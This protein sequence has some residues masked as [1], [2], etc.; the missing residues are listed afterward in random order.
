MRGSLKEKLGLGTIRIPVGIRFETQKGF[1]AILAAQVSPSL[2]ISEYV[3]NVI[4]D[5][6]WINHIVPYRRFILNPGFHSEIGCRFL[7]VERPFYLGPNFDIIFKSDHF[8][9]WSAGIKATLFFGK[10]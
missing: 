1:Y 10:N 2:F 5:S 8:I 6:V 9:I 7:V 3:K 4:D